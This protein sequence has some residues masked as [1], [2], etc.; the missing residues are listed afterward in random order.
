MGNDQKKYVC[1]HCKK[2][3]MDYDDVIESD[4]IVGVINESYFSE[5]YNDF[6]VNCIGDMKYFH[7]DETNEYYGVPNVCRSCIR[8]ILRGIAGENKELNGKLQELI[9]N[10]EPIKHLF[11]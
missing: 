8:E 11:F 2:N 10:N 3:A 7:D 1:F 5:M 6:F 9:R 4:G